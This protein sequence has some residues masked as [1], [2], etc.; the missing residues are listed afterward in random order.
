MLEYNPSKLL[1]CDFN[2]SVF[3]KTDDSFFKNVI[4]QISRLYYYKM[5]YT[6]NETHKTKT[7]DYLKFY[8]YLDYINY[9]SYR[10]SE[11]P[12]LKEE[13]VQEFLKRYKKLMTDDY[14]GEYWSNQRAM[15]DS[16]K[17]INARYNLV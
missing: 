8:S 2:E 14:S 1:N 5:R 7:F 12:N 11:N 6:G 16:I 17:E 10:I 9:V 4:E 15:Q 3:L 13:E